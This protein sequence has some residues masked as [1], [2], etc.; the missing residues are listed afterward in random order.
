VAGFLL[1][2]LVL[3]LAGCGGGQGN[4]DAAGDN[5]PGPC[6]LAVS[7][8]PAGQRCTKLQAC[9][10][11]EP[12]R[13]VTENLPGGQIGVTYRQT[14]EAAGGLP[15]YTW[16]IVAADPD[17][18]PLTLSSTGRLEGTFSGSVQGASLIVAV[19]DDG[20]GGGETVE[21][22]YTLTIV[23]CKEGEMQLCFAAAGG[24][25]RQ[26]TS[27]CSGGQVGPCQ[28][29]TDP[30]ADPKHC[31]PDCQ[32]CDVAISD[33]CREGLCACG[34]GTLC[35]GTDRCCSGTCLD[36]ATNL[37]NC[38]GCGASCAQ[39][40]AHA[41]AATLS[42]LGGTCDYSGPCDD[43]FLDCD[44]RRDNGCE[45]GMGL[46]NC[47]ACG[48]DCATQLLHVPAAQRICQSNGGTFACDYTGACASA[49]EDCDGDRGNGCET[50]LAEPAH[51]GT[52]QAD[53]AQSPAGQL[54][55]N[56]DPVRPYF[57]E[58]GCQFDS[59]TGLPEGCSA[60]QICCERICQE[61]ATDANHCGICSATC[62]SGGCQGGACGCAV[63]GDCPTP[64]GAPSCGASSRCVCSQGSAGG[65][66]CPLGQYCC[67]GNSGGSG[68]PGDKPDLGCCPKFCGQNSKDTPCTG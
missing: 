4:P 60:G 3:P 6:D 44:S 47:G 21:K 46:S 18:A 58:C 2:L 52:C 41:S 61:A 64:S 16:A 66:A 17:L 28:P 10:N 45:L 68:A 51:C 40:I 22:T 8:C 57:F 29:G 1:V 13:I 36:T 62:T 63:D 26:G 42:C 54:C 31:G 25:C 14:L 65:A 50:T 15:P 43:G 37:E 27:T 55:L 38:G 59:A 49:F 39:R 32:V 19:T 23:L 20:Y 30:S 12:L 34:N 24:V 9:V 56:P 48:R 35:S 33:V 67:D 53:C 5:G 7:P 11:A